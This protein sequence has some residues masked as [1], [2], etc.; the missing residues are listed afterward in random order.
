MMNKHEVHRHPKETK[1]TDHKT[2]PRRANPKPENFYLVGHIEADGPFELVTDKAKLSI[3]DV[4]LE[5]TSSGGISY[6][7]ELMATEPLPKHDPKHDQKSIAA[8]PEDHAKAVKR[9]EDHGYTHEKAE[10]VVARD[11]AAK[12]LATVPEKP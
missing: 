4:K 11:G 1:V 5:R 8:S 12:V 2:E 6:D 10:E 7:I 3:G 9:L